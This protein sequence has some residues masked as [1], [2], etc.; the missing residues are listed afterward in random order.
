MIDIIKGLWKWILWILAI[1]LL[2]AIILAFRL[3]VIDK[4]FD[5]KDPK[6][7]NKNSS[8]DTTTSSCSS[9]SSSLGKKVSNGLRGIGNAT[10]QGYEADKVNDYNTHNFDE[11]FLMYEGE[12]YEGTVDAVLEH[13]ISNSKGNFYARTSVTAVGFGDN[14]SIDYNGD[15]TEYQNSITNLRN[16]VPK[17]TYDISF[18]YGGFGTYVNEI[19]ITKK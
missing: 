12:T 6:S 5:G 1:L 14:I 18:K 4:D 11:T 16:S 13:L 2:G 19:V 15:V 8:S 17:G 3:F 10:V 7:K 9:S